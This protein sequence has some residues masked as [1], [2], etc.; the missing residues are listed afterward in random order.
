MLPVHATLLLLR[1]FLKVALEKG[2]G[3]QSYFTFS[4]NYVLIRY[5]LLILMYIFRVKV[6]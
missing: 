6:Q 5:L 2:I 1:E 3:V 4:Y